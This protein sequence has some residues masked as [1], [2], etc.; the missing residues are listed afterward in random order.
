[1]GGRF[2]DPANKGD[3]TSQQE[4]LSERLGAAQTSEV[5]AAS[6]ACFKQR[7]KKVQQV[8]SFKK[9]KS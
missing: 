7:V 2:H 9:L 8:H 3:P 5:F 1:M 6:I 4:P